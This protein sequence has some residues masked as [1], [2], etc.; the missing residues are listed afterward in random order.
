MEIH[1]RDV[2]FSLLSFCTWVIFLVA[3]MLCYSKNIGMPQPSSY[4]T[5]TRDTFQTSLLS[6]LGGKIV[7]ANKHPLSKMLLPIFVLGALGDLFGFGDICVYI[8]RCFRETT[9]VQIQ[10]PHSLGRF[11]FNQAQSF[12]G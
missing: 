3:N 12:I 5:I 4:Q 9:P 1:S 2:P 7:K 8:M 6:L 11:F 10:A